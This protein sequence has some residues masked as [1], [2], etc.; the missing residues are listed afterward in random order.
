MYKKN[1]IILFFFSISRIGSRTHCWFSSLLPSL[2][3]FLP[4]L[5]FSFFFPLP[6]LFLFA[7]FFF[8]FFYSVREGDE[9]GDEGEMSV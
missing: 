2:F 4:D 6:S 7:F 5:S 9:S 1:C 8:F 3:S